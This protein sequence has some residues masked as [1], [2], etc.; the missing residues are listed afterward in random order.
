[1]KEITMTTKTKTGVEAVEKAIEAGQ[2][3]LEAAFKAGAETTQKNF[4]KAVEF[5]KKQIDE[6]VKAM[7]EVQAFAKGN[8]EALVASGQA[9]AKGF[10]QL[11]AAATTYQKKAVED[12]TATAKTLMAA[13]TAKEFFE[14]QNTTAKTHYD[15]FVA[16]ASKMTELYMKVANEAME[17]MSTRFALAMEKFT[18]PVAR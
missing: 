17:P 11:A 13:K 2:E 8:V 1:V 18:K 16:E 14:I 9:A 5:S 15:A 6:T 7:D 12:A 10:E 3:R 4:E